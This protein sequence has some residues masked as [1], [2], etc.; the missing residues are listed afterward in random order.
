[1]PAQILHVPM[2][3]P[4]SEHDLQVQALVSSQ[5]NTPGKASQ[6][7]FA[8]L[9]P[10]AQSHQRHRWTLPTAF[11]QQYGTALDNLGSG[12]SGFIFSAV[13]RSDQ[14]EVA[15]K[16]LPVECVPVTSWVQDADY[17]CIPREVAT[18]KNIQ[19]SAVVA[20]I[21]LFQ[22]SQIV[23]IVME[24]FGSSWRTSQLT[25]S[26]PNPLPIVTRP[27]RSR[28]MDLFELLEVKQLTEEDARTIFVQLIE[29]VHYLLSQLSLVHG[30]IKD[31]N[32]LIDWSGPKPVA[33]FIDFGGAVSV[34]PGHLCGQ[35]N[36]RGTVEFASPE[37]ILGQ[38]YDPEKSE[39]WS[40][41]VLL[42]SMINRGCGPFA[43]R[44]ATVASPYRP[45]ICSPRCSHL[46]SRLLDKNPHTRA[47]IE[48]V[49]QHPWLK[50]TTSKALKF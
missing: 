8:A 13:R 36:F 46:I 17:G 27:K 28:A 21:D 7:F 24:L 1:M 10:S 26:D 15:V 16:L 3:P 43:T 22:D 41:G 25:S 20:F 18:L 19:H 33:K 38:A 5:P 31:E 44:Q 40:L 6:S 32:I 9:K 47:T 11:R 34:A 42:Y 37:I 23:L 2:P 30:D 4:P 45:L 12:G 35:A 14:K 50:R 48:E 39:T 49:L 29:C